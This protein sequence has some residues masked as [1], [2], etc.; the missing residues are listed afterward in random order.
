MDVQ[1]LREQLEKDLVKAASYDP[2]E[3]EDAGILRKAGRRW[4][5][6]DMDRLPKEASRFATK[7][8]SDGKGRFFL[9]FPSDAR[10]KKARRLF[11]KLTGKPFPKQ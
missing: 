4:E 9:E 1:E 3:L 6:I 5:V 2:A 10:R 8:S 7:A 11:T